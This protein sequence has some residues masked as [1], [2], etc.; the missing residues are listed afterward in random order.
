MGS[1]SLCMELKAVLVAKIDLT[2][3]AGKQRYTEEATLS[4]NDWLV[5]PI[6]ES[7]K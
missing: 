4:A 1:T 6:Q 3:T 2:L 5:G 7:L